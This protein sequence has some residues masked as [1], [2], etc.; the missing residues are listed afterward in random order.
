VPG[1]ASLSRGRLDYDRLPDV[2][3]STAVVIDDAADGST[4]DFGMLNSSVFDASATGVP[5]L[6]NNVLGAHDLFDASFP[7]WSTP[8]DIEAEVARP[9]RGSGRRPGHGRAVPAEVLARHTY[10]HR[11][12]ELGL[13][14][15]WFR[16]E[17]WAIAIGPRTRDDA[18][19]W[20]DTYFASAVRRALV[21][22]GR[23]IVHVRREW[24]AADGRADVVL[25][26]S[27]PGRRDRIPVPCPCC[28]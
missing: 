25:H 17:R 12:D 24:S 20:G 3:R 18:R 28:G 26:L 11:A 8:A 1:V 19:S 10:R 23:P 2:Y 22:R 13:V 15:R 14:D 16:A 27:A 7:T 4:R 9:S 5:V 6:T 21:R